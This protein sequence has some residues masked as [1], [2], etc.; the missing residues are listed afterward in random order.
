MLLRLSLIGIHAILGVCLLI[1]GALAGGYALPYQSAKAVGL[2][3]AVTAGI[4]DPSAVYSNPAALSEVQGN[5]ILG[6]GQYVNVVSS[7]KN[8]GRNS[9]N[10]RDDN[11]IPTLFGNYHIPATDLTVGVGLYTPFGLA[12]S[13]ND[14]SFSRFGAIRSELKP[15]Y[16]TPALA[17]R[18]HRSLSIGGGLSFVHASA[19][20]SR[21]LLLGAGAEGRIRLTD[22][23]NGY[24]YN[25]GLLFKP[26]DKIKFGLNYRGRVDLNFDTAQVKVADATGA[27]S[28]GR[29]KGTQLPLP[30]VISMGINWRIT[31][32]WEMEFVHDYTHWSEFRHLKAR[33]QPTF[34]G[35]TLRGLFIQEK[36]KD[37]NT[38]RFGSSHRLDD[39][40]RARAGLV[41]DESPIPSSTLG[42]SIPGGDSLTLNAGL[43]YQWRSWTVDLG[44]AAIFYKSRRVSNNVLEANGTSTLT[45]GRDR[46]ATFDNFVAVTIGYKF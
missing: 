27:I 3:N 4:D 8:S 41:L 31:P 7:V 29:S 33:F 12:T 14:G 16:I 9:R 26:H 20:F 24:T 44:Y 13:Y 35:G 18:I 25:L 19:L 30:P 38:L 6:G 37:T 43:G 15:F 23:D 40:W 28:T 42:P 17:W 46:Y 34:L 1:R 10:Q 11:L 36:W 5:Q 39:N 45:P 2:G 22:T 32:G 21:A